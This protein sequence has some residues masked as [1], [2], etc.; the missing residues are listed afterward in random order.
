MLN[1][2]RTSPE[3][4]IRAARDFVTILT[5]KLKEILDRVKMGTTPPFRP[6]V[7]PD[8]CPADM[9]RLMRACWAENPSDRPTIAEVRHAVKKIT[10]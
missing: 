2:L 7:S 1:N 5:E 9:L 8:E 6:E 4:A 3:S 10:K